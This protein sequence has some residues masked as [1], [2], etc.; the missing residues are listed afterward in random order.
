M[1]YQFIPSPYSSEN[2]WERAGFHAGWQL[3]AKPFVGSQHR[4]L[5][6]RYPIAS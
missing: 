2:V 5:P 3:S 1:H 6:G 4:Y